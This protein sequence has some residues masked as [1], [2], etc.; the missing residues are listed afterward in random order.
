MSDEK[1]HARWTHADLGAAMA[2]TVT[3][4]FLDSAKMLILR[5]VA[6]IYRLRQ[7]VR[8]Q[9]RTIDET[10][11][12]ADELREALDHDARPPGSKAAPEEMIPEPAD[13]EPVR[14]ADD[15]LRAL[16]DAVEAGELRNVIGLDD[17]GNLADGSILIGLVLSDGSERLRVAVRGWPEGEA[18]PAPPHDCTAA[19]MQA[20]GQGQEEGMRDMLDGLHA[21][22]AAGPVDH[23]EVAAW[24]AEQRKRLAP[25]PEAPAPA[26]AEAGAA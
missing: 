19:H 12:I 3:H 9:R 16:G 18:A 5:L 7:R 21:F 6:E 13:M 8:L 1:K 17:E 14:T 4:T 24:V 10:R 25:L 20:H 11:R 23:H 15:F 2:F 22:L 26:S